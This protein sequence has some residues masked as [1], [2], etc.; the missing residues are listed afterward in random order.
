V[1]IIIEIEWKYRV[2]AQK[3]PVGAKKGAGSPEGPALTSPSSAFKRIFI[4]V[5]SNEDVLF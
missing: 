1:E 3:K 2:G 4:L 5:S